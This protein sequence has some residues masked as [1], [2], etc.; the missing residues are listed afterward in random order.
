M[1]FSTRRWIGLLLAVFMFIPTVVSV[2]VVVI[3]S[4][5]AKQC[6]AQTQAHLPLPGAPTG[7]PSESQAELVSV[8]HAQPSVIHGRQATFH[9]QASTAHVVSSPLHNLAALAVGCHGSLLPAA[10]TQYQAS[11]QAFVVTHPA[12]ELAAFTALQAARAAQEHEAQREA[13]E[14]LAVAKHRQQ[15]QQFLVAA[16]EAQNEKQREVRQA[17]AAAKHQQQVQQF[18]VVAAAH[19]AQ[20]GASASTVSHPVSLPSP[21]V[22]H[23]AAVVA[24]PPTPA[25]AA[26]PPVSAPGQGGLPLPIQYLQNGTVDQG[27]DYAAPGGTPLFAMGSGTIIRAGI[28]GFGPN[29]PVLHIA[30]GPLAGRAVYYGHAGQNLV[31][32]G[33]RVAQGQQISIVGNGRVGISS[34]PHLEIGFYPP[35]PNGAGQAMLEHINSVVGHNTGR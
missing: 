8:V 16:V 4:A 17:L 5:L 6:R 23:A 25:T 30:S 22:T 2:A 34:G 19:R 20:L 26:S 24:T 33:A 35:G 27:V 31:P 32:V 10:T 11:G 1:R 21:P 12:I 3:Y 29:A 14:A 18:L 7:Q 9:A 13:L 15:V 28:A